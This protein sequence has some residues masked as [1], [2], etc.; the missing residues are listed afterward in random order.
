MYVHRSGSNTSQQRN[1]KVRVPQL[2]PKDGQ[3]HLHRHHNSVTRPARQK[4]A[5]SLARRAWRACRICDSDDARRLARARRLTGTGHH[6]RRCNGP[7]R[8]ALPMRY[9]SMS[10]WLVALVGASQGVSRPPGSNLP[11]FSDLELLRQELNMSFYMYP[12][13]VRDARVRGSA[14]DTASASQQ[15]HSN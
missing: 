7:M 3:H 12:K 5:N 13:A 4:G 9:L 8:G 15:S 14:Q 6:Q 1:V 2:D 11:I 10:L